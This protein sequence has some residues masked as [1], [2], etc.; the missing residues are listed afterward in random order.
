MTKVKVVR[1]ISLGGIL[2]AMA[3]ILQSSPVFLPTIGLLLSPSSTLPIALASVI[4]PYF[5]FMVLLSSV[6]ILIAVSIQEALILLFTTGLLG[7]IMGGLIYRKGIFASIFAS[8][9]SLIIGMMILTYVLVIPGFVSFTSSLSIITIV[10][11]YFIFSF[12]I[13]VSGYYALE[14]LSID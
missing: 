10:I 1:Y 13:H 6:L 3:V 4:N 11:I 9:I 7:L 2:T 5:S 14:N 8:M 12:F